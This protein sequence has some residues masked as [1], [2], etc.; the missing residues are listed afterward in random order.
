MKI[1]GKNTRKIGMKKDRCMQYKPK[2]SL[3]GRGEKHHFRKVFSR[4]EYGTIWYSE[5]N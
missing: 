1:K 5:Q 4:E 2:F 3:A